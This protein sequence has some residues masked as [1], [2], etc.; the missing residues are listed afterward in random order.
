MYNV[1]KYRRASVLRG[2]G[3][4]WAWGLRA[5]V[6][7]VHFARIV[8]ARLNL[9][10]MAATVTCFLG[11]LFLLPALLFVYSAIKCWRA[12]VGAWAVWAVQGVEAMAGVTVR[13]AM[14]S[15]SSPGV[16]TLLLSLAGAPSLAHMRGK[17]LEEVVERRDAGGRLLH[18][19]LQRRLGKAGGY[20]VWLR[21]DA[22]DINQHVTLAPVHYQNRLLTS[23][24]MQEYVSEVVSQPLPQDLPP[25]QVTLIT[26]CDGRS[27][28][29]E[30][31]VVARAHHLL[32]SSL[33]LPDLLV[34]AYPDP[35]LKPGSRGL[36][37][38]TAPAAT[39]RLAE[40]V[41]R[42]VTRVVE[43][44]RVGYTSRGEKLISGVLSPALALLEEAAQ[45]S[46]KMGPD[47][48][49]VGTSVVYLTTVLARRVQTRLACVWDVVRERL[50]E[51]SVLRAGFCCALCAL[52]LL[53]HCMVWLARLPLR[54]VMWYFEAASLAR[55]V[56]ASEEVSLVVEAT[57]EMYW[58]TRAFVSLPRL[59]LETLC[60][61]GDT[62][63]M[64]WT[65][66]HERRLSRRGSGRQ[67]RGGITVAWSDPVPLS[68]VRGVRGVTGASLGEVLLTA[69]A[70]AVRDYLR[71]T[72]LPV[73]EEV[74]STV[75]V[76]SQRWAE[77]RGEE[78]NSTGLVT[79]A[80][81]T[82]AAEASTALRLV[83]QSIMKIQSYP[84]R[85]LASVWLIRNV[86]YFLPASLLGATFRA[87][88]SRYPVF[89]SN[90]AGPQKPVTLWGH[91]LLNLFHWR[92]PCDGA[93]LS[94]C[95]TSYRG[96][97]LLGV[98]ADGRVV[99][100]VASLPQAFVTHLNELAVEVGVRLERRQNSH[101]W[102]RSATPPPTPPPTPTF[103][104][105]PIRFSPQ[106]S[107][108]R[109]VPTGAAACGRK[110]S[111][112]CPPY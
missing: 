70:G 104:N 32:A 56:V 85:Y 8:E 112:V 58:M 11:F 66:H 77:G 12:A 57:V 49:P 89:L 31:W 40:A 45:A 28:E 35:W 111:V 95:V 69:S 47:A 26:T 82:G 41:V 13:G 54:L 33:S 27:G 60:V 88:S 16:H 6:R 53:W 14:E 39:A 5:W 83:R 21:H 68:T 106:W 100:S 36:S 105:S 15:A 61:R 65:G 99:P 67:A 92:P 71:V 50:R 20:S 103:K 4:R 78:V 34:E 90:L 102:F 38:L 97:A 62:P 3:R 37:I 44:L 64:G 51:F 76:Y 22:F 52:R 9:L 87:L 107:Q 110:F 74:S 73:P 94:V 19:N 93:V 29:G 91:D 48:V 30:T 59:V 101:S 75:P 17:I 25:W 86:A 96:Q 80:L 2:A 24:N 81:P 10:K 98:V 108:R 1:V 46:C 42:G 84:E 18:P 43:R 63:L 23:R 109:L 79:L 55:R 7:A 72:G